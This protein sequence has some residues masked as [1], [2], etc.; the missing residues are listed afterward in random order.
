MKR[1]RVLLLNLSANGFRSQRKMA[2]QSYSQGINQQKCVGLFR[3]SDWLSRYAHRKLEQLKMCETCCVNGRHAKNTLNI[4]ISRH[5]FVCHYLW[6]VLAK[7]HDNPPNLHYPINSVKV[8]VFLPKSY[9]RFSLVKVRK[10]L[11]ARLE[12]ISLD[13]TA[14]Q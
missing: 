9:A 13:K 4:K 6:N 5:A 8:D 2:A 14:N 11:A 12:I 7:F 10:Q 1:P 3:Y